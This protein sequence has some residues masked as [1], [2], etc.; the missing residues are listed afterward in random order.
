MPSTHVPPPKSAT[1]PSIKWPACPACGQM[2]RLTTIEPHERYTNLDVRNFACECGFTKSDTF[3]AALSR[4]SLSTTSPSTSFDTLSTVSDI[5]YKI[6][7]TAPGVCIKLSDVCRSLVS[8]QSEKPP[9][10]ERSS[11]CA[12]ACRLEGRSCTVGRIAR[13]IADRS[14]VKRRASWQPRQIS[15]SCCSPKIRRTCFSYSFLIPGYL[16]DAEQLPEMLAECFHSN[17][18]E[19]LMQ[20]LASL[21]ARCSL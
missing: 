13:D 2:L 19:E 4:A 7:Q 11:R 9:P 1:P 17:V 15:I 3:N 12:P 6:E 14:V 16:C 18:R 5:V 8:V 20:P 21:G 10:C